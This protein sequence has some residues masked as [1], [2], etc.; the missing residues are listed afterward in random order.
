MCA[1]NGR[2]IVSLSFKNT[3]ELGQ[4]NLQTT[5]IIQR[6]TKLA[7][8][9]ASVSIEHVHNKVGEHLFA[10]TS[11]WRQHRRATIIWTV[12]FCC[13]KFVNFYYWSVSERKWAKG[14]RNR[15]LFNENRSFID[16]RNVRFEW[17]VRTTISKSPF[18]RLIITLGSRAA[19]L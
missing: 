1:R 9:L 4:S 10:V 18:S 15:R 11:T 2:R 17:C 3:H 14:P 16:V 6:K 7:R 12:I 19:M 8:H 13:Q 5:V